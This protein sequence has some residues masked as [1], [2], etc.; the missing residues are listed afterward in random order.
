MSLGFASEKT[1][2]TFHPLGV[3]AYM[4]ISFLLPFQETPVSGRKADVIKAAHL[5]AEAALRLVKPGNQV[6]MGGYLLHELV[7]CFRMG[8]QRL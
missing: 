5:C 4:N 7:S 1:L 8:D 6:T 3:N 2:V